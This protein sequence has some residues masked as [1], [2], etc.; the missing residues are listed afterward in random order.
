MLDIKYIRENLK[1]VRRALE[2]KHTKFDLDGL[3]KLDEKRRELLRKI[4]E[5]RAKKNQLSQKIAIAKIGD[6]EMRMIKKEAEK[7]K[8]KLE[9]LEP[10]LGKIEQL[11]NE[12][13]A[14]MHNIP[15]ST[16]PHFKEGSKIERRWGSPRK[17]DFK[18]KTHIEIG[19]ALDIIDIKRAAKVSGSRMGF[20]KN[21]GALLELALINFLFEK[22][23][24]KGFIPMI[25]PAL[26]K[27]MAMFGT[28]FFP[29]EKVEYYKME[30]DNLYLAGT[31]EV[32]LCAYHANEILEEEELPKRYCGF[33]SCFRREAGSYGRDTYGLLRVHQFDKVE[34]FIFAQ[35]K[36][37]WQ[38]FENLQKI[39]EE[40]LKDLGLPYQVVNMH[41]GDIGAPNAKKYDTE[42]WLPGQGRYREL[43]SCSHD[44]DF[45][46]RRLNIK[47]RKKDGSTEFLHTLNSTASAIGRTIIAILENYQEK[48]GSVKVPKVLQKYTGFKEIRKKDK[49][50]SPK[51]S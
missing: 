32:P 24:K 38:E 5:L 39:V 33:S 20:L 6:R 22:L 42:V 12:K 45:Q 3:L 18:P 19:K 44:T 49:K 23:I 50:F 1:E 7:V 36:N 29:T 31:A 4:E 25:V 15:H 34:M 2:K 41:G 37:S 9:K 43:T 47:Y 28:G 13:M 17:F 48:D 8:E 51:I 30:K 40:I 10:E 27:E 14:L 16:V 26:V 11:F 46:A 21:E 35:P